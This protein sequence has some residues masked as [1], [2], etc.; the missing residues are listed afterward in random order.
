MQR[1]HVEEMRALRAEQDPPERF[2][3]NQENANEASH[4]HANLNASPGKDIREEAPNG[5]IGKTSEDGAI[6]AVSVVI[7][8]N[9]FV[10]LSTEEKHPK[11]Y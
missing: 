1:R 5:R 8:N 4:N 10:D 3:L 11:L 7:E 6:V 9:R 2:A